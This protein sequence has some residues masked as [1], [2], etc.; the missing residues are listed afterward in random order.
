M[1]K[2]IKIKLKKKIRKLFLYA[3]SEIDDRSK[4]RLQDIIYYKLSE[5]DEDK[6]IIGR[7][8]LYTMSFSTIDEE[9]T[10]KALMLNSYPELEALQHAELHRSKM[11]E[12]VPEL[13]DLACEGRFLISNYL[14]NSTLGK[15][16]KPFS[17]YH[18]TDS[19]IGDYTYIAQNSYISMTTI[20][21]FCSIGPNF[22]CGWGIHPLDGIS[23]HPM[24]FST[25]KQN[26]MTLSNQDK[27]IER[28][29]IVIGND[30][31]IGANVT[32]LD[33]VTIGNGAVIG[34]GAVVSKN[35]P[36]Y[37]IAVGCPIKII[38]YRFDKETCDK[39]NLSEWWNKEDDLPRV[40]KNIF[41]VAQFTKDGVY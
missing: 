7:F 25:G 8:L 10:L 12:A 17:P 29:Q 3:F 19:E 5:T 23:T 32:I 24:F 21:K 16:T 35:I 20:G 18:L 11:L 15:H 30:V 39:L 41:N 38:R 13:H 37:A 4:R 22:L 26:G 14:H 33:G 1:F 40:E 9:N 36:P 31:F 34:A 2:W 6:S 28:Q 27:V